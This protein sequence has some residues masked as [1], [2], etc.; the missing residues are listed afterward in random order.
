MMSPSVTAKNFEES[1]STMEEIFLN[2]EDALLPKEESKKDLEIESRWAQ[3]EIIALLKIHFEMDTAFQYVTPKDPLWEDVSRKLLELGYNRSAK[4]CKEKFENIQ[5]YHKRDEEGLVDDSKVKGTSRKGRKRRREKGSKTTKTMMTFFEE[6]MRQVVER[7]D[8]M[9]HRFLKALE[10]WERDRMVRE[11]AWRRQE[12][13]RLTH[14]KELM[15]QEHATIAVREQ[16]IITFLHKVTGR[17]IPIPPLSTTTIATTPQSSLSQQQQQ[18]SSN[19]T[20]LTIIPIAQQQKM[21]T[22][23]TT[24]EFMSPRWPKM[25][26][27]ALIKLRTNLESFYREGLKGPLWEQIAIGMQQLGYN[28]SAKK[29]KEKWENVNKYFKKIKESNK[30]R[31]ENSRTCSYFNQLNAFYHNRSLSQISRIFQQPESSPNPNPTQQVDGNALIT[32]FPSQ[33]ELV[34]GETSIEGSHADNNNKNKENFEGDFGC[35]N[36][37]MTSEKVQDAG[38]ELI[39][40]SNQAMVD[41]HDKLEEPNDENIDQEDENQNGDQNEHGE[42]GKI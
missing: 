14:E 24:I 25:E 36:T 20:E 4:K 15:T 9:Q 21:L 6:M 42:D 28:R 2:K 27:H 32:M 3:Q 23:N 12:I 26:V 35:S 22:E 16:A 38:K 5:R 29:C 18:Q 37:N 30:N 1:D 31:S 19:D 34:K 10:K 41:D 13:A 7:Q 8:A 40:P 17:A 39:D 11:E 33:L